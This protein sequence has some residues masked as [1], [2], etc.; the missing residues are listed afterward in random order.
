LVQVVLVE[1]AVLTQC[2]LLLLLQVEVL[3][4]A[5]V[6]LVQTAVQV[7]VLV[8]QTSLMVKS[9]VVFLAL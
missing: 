1:Q 8:V 3:A 5:L 9:M 2:F 4:E 7:A 6:L